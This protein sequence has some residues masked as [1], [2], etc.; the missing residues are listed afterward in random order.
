MSTQYNHLS[1]EERVTKSLAWGKFLA[2]KIVCSQVG[3][4]R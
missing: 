3:S 1:T 4:V 2:M